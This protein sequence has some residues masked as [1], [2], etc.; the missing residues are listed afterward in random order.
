MR[1][2]DPPLALLLVL[3]AA[4][5][6]PKEEGLSIGL[7]LPRTGTL[8][9]SG[10]HAESAVLMAAERINLAGGVAGKPITLAI[11]D[12]RSNAATGVEAAKKLLADYDVKGIIGPEEEDVA[13]TMVELA[14]EKKLV[15]ISGGI[16][17][18]R[19][20]TIDDGG[21]FF[22]TC[23]STQVT[24][25]ALAERMHADGMETASF[26]FVPNDFGTAFVSSA[27]IAYRGLGGTLKSPGHLAA[28]VTVQPGERDYRAV[29]N[30]VLPYKPQ[31]L[32]IVADPLT[33][34]RLV[35]DWKLLGGNA[36]LYLAPTL[37]TE[38]FVRGVPA[39]ALEGAV[40][41][42]A[43]SG[44][45]DGSFA[46]AY[47][48][49]VGGPPA[50]SAY[51]YYDAMALMALAIE[52]ATKLAGAEPSGDQIRAAL[53]EV[54]SPP[55]AK[56]RWDELGA[57]LER[58]AAGEDVDYDGASGAIDFDANGDVTLRQVGFWRVSASSIVR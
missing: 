55:G 42:S 23:P 58:V 30:E 29:L 33:G 35:S 50:Q 36:R 5:P 45:A 57:G 26:L 2:T 14:R 54:A 4:C 41:V 13:T 7:L 34:A 52:R 53:F 18:P 20:T 3:L 15:E 31:A 12:T 16:T 51:F 46:K 32:L 38:V 1:R 40:G 22:R 9:D 25:T 49:A 11:K 47:A 19:F 24:A 37:M 28:P 56:V 10:G 17:S 27:V 39:G 48:D 8:A 43:L 6:A 44:D 21:Y